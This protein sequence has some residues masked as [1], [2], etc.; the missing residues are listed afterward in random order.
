MRRMLVAVAQGAII[1]K[2]CRAC[3]SGGAC[4]VCQYIMYTDMS[5]LYVLGLLCPQ[6]LPQRCQQC[7]LLWVTT[8]HV[9]KQAGHHESEGA[10]MAAGRQQ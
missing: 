3:R 10:A 6:P 4:H 8:R 7:M 5:Y 9:C 1:I 2:A